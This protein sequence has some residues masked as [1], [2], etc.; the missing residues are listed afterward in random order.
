MDR[1]LI[2]WNVPNMVT[3]PLMAFGA[4]L[5][6]GLIWQLVMKAQGKS[7]PVDNNAPAPVD[8]STGGFIQPGM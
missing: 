5:V 3:V 1:T 4:F 6:V 2:S 8:V 7:G